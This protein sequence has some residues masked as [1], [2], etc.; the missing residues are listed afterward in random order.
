MDYK[1]KN[2][3]EHISKWKIDEIK[4]VIQ[5]IKSHKVFGIVSFDGI[6]GNQF[7]KMR[8]MLHDTAV[9]K[10]MR[11]TLIEK[12][13]L[14]ASFDSKIQS[15]KDYISN[16]TALIFTNENPFKLYK[17]LESVKTKSPLK[18]GS[19][20]P[21][22]IY[23]EKG[24][25][26]FPPGPLLGDFQSAGIPVTIESGK[27]CIKESKIVCREG[28]KVSLKLANALDKLEIYPIDVGLFLR[29]AYESGNLFLSE[30]L[31]INVE[32]YNSDIINCINESFNLSLNISYVT[33]DTIEQILQ[34]SYLN[35][36]NISV[37]CVV[38][39]KDTIEHLI[40]KCISS[41]YLLSSVIMK[42]DE[43]CL[44]ENLKSE[45]KKMEI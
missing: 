7:Q 19:I 31:N 8:K 32:K 36:L 21:I 27:I 1:R 30:D 35:S 15:M 34:H 14:D 20:S 3:S 13:L 24:P 25:T 29:V 33:K 6:L 12:V 2:G 23:I 40:S 5:L 45:I 28:E 17:L 39:T 18:S 22:D 11:N 26:S 44:S 37:N 9:L 16:Q 4:E 38:Y 43:N 41:M 42:K 10:V